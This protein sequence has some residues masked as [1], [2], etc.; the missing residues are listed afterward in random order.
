MKFDELQKALKIFSITERVTLQ[1]IKARHRDLVKQFHPDSGE[2]NT[3]AIREVNAAYEVIMA[4]CQ[5]YRFSFNREEFLE[6]RPEE[7]LRWQFADDP[8]WGG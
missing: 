8:I 7:R 4:Y 6:Q 2:G 1:E 5:N 3:Q